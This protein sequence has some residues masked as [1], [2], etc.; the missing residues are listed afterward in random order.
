MSRGHN[1]GGERALTMRRAVRARLA[2]S[3]AEHVANG[4][5]V[6]TAGEKMNLTK[7][8][9]ARLWANIKRELGE[10]AR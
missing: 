5:G 6:N 10:Q 8:Q 3:L 2:D 7:G 4:L 1:F 9:T